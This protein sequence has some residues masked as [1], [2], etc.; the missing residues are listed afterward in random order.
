MGRNKTL[1]NKALLPF[2]FFWDIQNATVKETK[3]REDK[4][5]RVLGIGL[6]DADREYV[7]GVMQYMNRRKDLPLC[8]YAFT[9]I[10]AAAEAAAEKSLATILTGDMSIC[11][12]REDGYYIGNTPCV[13]LS[14]LPDPGNG[15]VFKYQSLPALVHDIMRYLLKETDLGSASC[16]LAAV[17]S[18]IGRCGKTRFAKAYA[19]RATGGLYIGMEDFSDDEPTE[20]LY[21]MKNRL[22]ELEKRLPGL[23]RE[24]NGLSI[25]SSS[26]LAFDI[27]CISREDIEYL[28][29]L[30]SEMGRYSRIVYD[31]GAAAPELPGLFQL[32]DVIY[33]PVLTDP[34]SQR[35]LLR[36]RRVLENLGMTDVLLK[37]REVRLPDADWLSEEMQAAVE[38]AM[39]EERI[40]VGGNEGKVEEAVSR[41]PGSDRGDTGQ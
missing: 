10:E 27:H 35:K 16:R 37:L 11:E 34:V 39:E 12:R 24:E 5:L 4:S 33:M 21:L 20:L 3:D 40:F 28:N 9:R 18:P 15:A 31:L 2:S 30:L 41:T 13:Y 19:A 38:S 36:F 8:C 1:R 7:Y 6:C 22:P 29:G 32:F 26:G 25:L 17:F 23:I 14:A